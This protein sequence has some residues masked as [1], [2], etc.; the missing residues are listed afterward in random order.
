MSDSNDLDSA[1]TACDAIAHSADTSLT[2]E[3]DGR[4]GTATAAFGADQLPGVQGV[5]GPHFQSTW[6]V[7][8]IGNAPERVTALAGRLGGLRGGQAL[9]V[10][11]AEADVVLI[12]N[13]PSGWDI[14]PRIAAGLDAAFAS[15]CFDAEVSH[16]PLAGDGSRFMTQA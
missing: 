3:W 1:R 5:L 2:W 10:S 14:A 15:D 16:G 4:F 6:S 7:A 9:W 11:A 12:S 13:T 8:E